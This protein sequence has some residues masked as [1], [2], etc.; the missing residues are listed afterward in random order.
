MWRREKKK[1]TRQA[2]AT[3]AGLERFVDWTNLGVSESAE[4]EE[5]MMS[6]LVYGFTERMRKREG[7]A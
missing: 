1:K 2:K 4:E 6:G 5:A 7:S 3:G